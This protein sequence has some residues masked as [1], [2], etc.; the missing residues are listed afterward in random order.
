MNPAGI[1]KSA[2]LPALA[3]L[4]AM[5]VFLAAPSANTQTNAPPPGH[6]T[7]ITPRPT[8]KVVIES[9]P[10][11]LF[12][13]ASYA[14]PIRF[15]IDGADTARI[16]KITAVLTWKNR[17][18]QD[19]IDISGRFVAVSKV[20]S[21]NG[22][23]AMAVVGPAQN[24]GS[25][26]TYEAYVPSSFYDGKLLNQAACD[27]RDW[28]A[29]Y[30]IVV[31]FQPT[32]NGIVYPWA[33]EIP[34]E[35]STDQKSAGRIKVFADERVFC[36]EFPVQGLNQKQGTPLYGAQRIYPLAGTQLLVNMPG[37]DRFY[38]LN[39]SSEIAPLPA[40]IPINGLASGTTYPVEFTPSK[41]G[42]YAQ[43]GLNVAEA[44][45]ESGPD[46]INCWAKLAVTSANPDLL[47]VTY[48]ATAY[49]NRRGCYFYLSYG[50][51]FVE[52]LGANE[53]AMNLMFSSGMHTCLLFDGAASVIK[54]VAPQATSFNLLGS[55]S[56]AFGIGWAIAGG[57]GP[58]AVGFG[59]A[60]S[61]AAIM[62]SCDSDDSSKKQSADARI[63][64]G[65]VKTTPDNSPGVPELKPVDTSGPIVV[66][67]VNQACMVGEQYEYFVQ[68]DAAVTCDPTQYRYSFW[69][70]IQC[71]SK[72]GFYTSAADL[73]DVMIQTQ[74]VA[75]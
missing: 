50:G 41:S 71:Y 68:V 7:E 55:A 58:F 21:D 22:S 26:N 57:G 1:R 18:R 6:S 39:E 44:G 47:P 15:S 42:G 64:H 11:Y 75:P 12:G 60:S 67:R 33:R 27:H 9:V 17:T 49:G 40:G 13:S 14:T 20:K 25:S 72:A 73:N 19:G 59:I 36:V 69:D 46:R 10:E 38:Q 5:I 16:G 48:K 29:E 34:S 65:F 70:D 30:S 54:Q 37:S 3:G 51:R 56:G 28:K 63:T 62:A 31:D 66:T 52:P 2:A 23:V 32:I 61:V 53:P 45:R 43:E 8:C 24:N 4:A 74:G 35:P